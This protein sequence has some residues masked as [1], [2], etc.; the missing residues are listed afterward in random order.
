MRVYIV[1]I[2]DRH[3]DV[4]VKVF[5]PGS[6]GMLRALTCARRAAEKMSR[7]RPDDIR[8]LLNKH[9]VDAGWVWHA[10]VGP[11]NDAVRVEFQELG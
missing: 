10:Q 6:G 9:M 4:E 3:S 2:E 8:M 1:I 11:E 7:G 5:E